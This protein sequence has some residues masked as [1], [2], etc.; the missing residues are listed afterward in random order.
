[1]STPSNSWRQPPT[2]HNRYSPSIILYLPYASG[3]ASIRR[4]IGRLAGGQYRLCETDM[5]DWIGRG[6]TSTYD[7]KATGHIYIFFSPSRMKKAILDSGH[8]LEKLSYLICLRDPRD[9]LV[10]LYYLTQDS[11]HLA[12]AEGSPIYEQMLIAAQKAATTQLDDYVLDSIASFKPMMLELQHILAEVPAQ[13]VHHLSYAAL[14]HAF[15]LFLAGL[16]NTLGVAPSHQT[17]TDIL[18]TEDIQRPKTLHRDS[19]AHFP[20]A[21]PTPGRHKRDLQPAS[22]KR[23]Y[24]EFASTLAWMAENDLPEFRELYS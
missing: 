3:G 11:T 10:S 19:L 6:T 13:K 17:I 2:L 15:P 22:V 5:E 4:I 18:H 7:I 14:C 1:M 12:I 24:R 21:S 8:L 16:V 9:L 20:K 23:L